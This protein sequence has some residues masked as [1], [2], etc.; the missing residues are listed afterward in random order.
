MEI[1]IF[2]K[3]EI[4]CLELYK[5]FTNNSRYYIIIIFENI[6]NKSFLLLNIA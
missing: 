5:R 4:K 3:N 6:F 1:I 2:K